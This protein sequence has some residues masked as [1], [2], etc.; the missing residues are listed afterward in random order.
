MP[1][2]SMSSRLRRALVVCISAFVA[3][4]LAASVIAADAWG[5]LNASP[6]ST[7]HRVY[8]QGRVAALHPSHAVRAVDASQLTVGKVKSE[9]IDA[10]SAKVL[11][12]QLASSV[13]GGNAVSVAVADVSGKVVAAQNEKT[14]VEPASTMKTLTAFA[15]SVTLNMQDTL[16]TSVKLDKDTS[17]L[18]LVGGGDILLKNG[19]SD[20]AHVNGRAGLVT[21]AQQTAGALSSRGITQVSLR[22]DN[23]LFNGDTLPADLNASSDVNQAYRNLIQ[24]TTMAVDEAREWGGAPP[25]NPDG[26]GQWLPER[27]ITPAYDTAAMFAQALRAQGITVDTSSLA[28]ETASSKAFDVASVQSAPLWQI[29]GLMLTNSDNSLAQLFG[30]LLALHEKKENSYKG[31]AEAVLSVLKQY[32]VPTDGLA[33]A[34]TSGLEPGSRLTVQTLVH[35]QSAFLNTKSATWP[36][37][38]GLPVSQLSGTLAARDFG[39]EARGLVRAKTGTLDTVTAL[40]G[41]V[42]RLNGSALIFA[43]VVN[44]SDMDTAKTAVNSFVKG[45]VQL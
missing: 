25:Q 7:I 3:L 30:R 34:D 44:G 40:A 39:A 35:V 31:A 11:I 37:E 10:Q 2:E 45:L 15:S 18:T 12:D 36:A 14:A 22:F 16:K 9:K 19:E 42:S 41:N 24:T 5:L 29:L 28:H 38:V 13:G 43:V 32:G 20:P 23:G 6:L 1:K 27:S 8:A 33:I 21:L 17:T 4:C 26:E